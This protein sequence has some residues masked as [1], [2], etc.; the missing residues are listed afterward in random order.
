MRMNASH[1]PFV[2]TFPPEISSYILLLSM[3]EW[4]YE[5]GGPYG[6][7]DALLKKLPTPFLLGTVCRR[8]RQLARSSPRLWTTLSFTLAKPTKVH[9]FEVVTD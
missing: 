6:S 7:C 4:D 9:L 2:L 1:D 8:W 5:P 3:E